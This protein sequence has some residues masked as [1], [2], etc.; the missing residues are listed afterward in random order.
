MKLRKEFWPGY[1]R[2]SYTESSILSLLSL[3]MISV[4]DIRWL[5]NS[6]L[7]LKLGLYSFCDYIKKVNGYSWNNICD[8]D[9]LNNKPTSSYNIACHVFMARPD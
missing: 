9:L 4:R 1:S 8:I 2:M 7:S 6:G 3:T 5:S